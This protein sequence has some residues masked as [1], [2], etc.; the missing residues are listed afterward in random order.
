MRQTSERYAILD[1]VLE[2]RVHFEVDELYRDIASE[3]HVSRAT[4]YNT[5]E[6]LCEC[7]ILRRHFLNENQAAYELSDD[8]H[9]HLI[10]MECGSVKEVRDEV[11]FDYLSGL[12]FR[13]FHPTATVT[14][15]YGICSKCLRKGSNKTSG[16]NEKQIKP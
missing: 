1:K 6:L 16:K 15:V 12:K 10:C 7:N 2:Q 8:K 5:L 4:V 9:L 14:N 13:G 3:Y 11:V